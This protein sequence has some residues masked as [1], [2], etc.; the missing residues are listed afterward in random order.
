MADVLFITPVFPDANGSGRHKR[1][2]QWLHVL[3]AGH[4]RVHLLVVVN[5]Q[6]HS[7]DGQA[8]Q[9]DGLASCRVLVIRHDRRQ[10][11]MALPWLILRLIVGLR[12]SGSPELLWFPLGGEQRESLTAWY[13]SARFDRIVCFRFY[14][15]EMARFV[16]EMV[17]G[18]C[19]D[20][21]MDDL[22]SETGWKIAVLCL[23]NGRWVKALLSCLTTLQFFRLEQ[24]L[25]RSFD[26]VHLC[27]AADRVKLLARFPGIST[28]LFPNRLPA[29]PAIQ[30]DSGN[31][32]HV[33]FVGTL[34]YYPNEQAVC[35]FASNVLPKLLCA[36][37]GWRFI[38]AG[39]N[40]PSGLTT[41]LTK[42]PGAVFLGAIDD[43]DPV[44]RQVGIVVSPLQAGGGTKLK[45]LEAIQQNRPVVASSE[46][47]YGLE[48]QP[49]EHFL[50]ANTVDE[51]VRH[52]LRLARDPELRARLTE[53]ARIAVA[54]N[55]EFPG[56][57]G[58]IDHETVG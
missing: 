32:Q 56:T 18:T 51:Y 58:S 31:P 3:A 20:L 17:G 27:S 12:P 23:K 5:G 16:A 1:A 14:L 55:Y 30:D 36:D 34:G 24:R 25:V 4:H 13:G 28:V 37:G 21:D 53:Q 22:D 11:L 10:A 26:T 49:D 39:F 43:L 19:C 35:W 6:D 2:H 57:Q 33:L 38:V 46:T 8:I 52:C 15:S 9:T 54:G 42:Q 41:W 29:R 48:L 44:Y 7:P 47:V 50:L 45:M 40:A